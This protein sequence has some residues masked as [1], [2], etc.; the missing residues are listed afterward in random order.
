MNGCIYVP[1][2]FLFGWPSVR[3]ILLAA[4]QFSVNRWRSFLLSPTPLSYQFIHG[5]GRWNLQHST[6]QN[7]AYIYSSGRGVQLTL[8]TVY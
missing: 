7:S 6:V 4:W 2:F 1:L 3:F 5:A 8:F